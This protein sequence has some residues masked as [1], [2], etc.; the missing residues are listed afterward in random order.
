[1]SGSHASDGAELQD[2]A[3][4]LGLAVDRTAC[5][6]VARYLDAMLAENEHVNLTGV[7]DPARALR[8]HALDALAIAG[9]VP[10]A[11]ARALDLGTGNG[12]PGVAVAALWPTCPVVLCDRT[13]RKVAAIGRALASCELPNATAVHC[14]VEQARARQPDWLAAFDLVTARAVALPPGVARLALP[15][16]APAGRLALWITAHTPAP[17]M[18]AGGLRRERLFAYRIT[19]QDERGAPD[20]RELRIALW[21]C[22]TG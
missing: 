14:D 20:E 19:A 13:Q 11:P 16:L 17:A 21:R 12:F 6:R 8:L 5:D 15:L 18:L 7:R 3:R 2:L 9:A 1:M 10:A 22:A 4:G